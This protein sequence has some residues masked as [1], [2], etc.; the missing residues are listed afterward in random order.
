MTTKFPSEIKRNQ[1][2]INDLKRFKA[3]ELKNILFYQSVLL[4]DNLMDSKDHVEFFFSYIIAMRLLNKKKVDELDLFH[5]FHLLL[6][7]VENYEKLNG[8]EHLTYN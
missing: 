3:N 5:A 6:Y 1:R 2:S 8:K 7:F 4:C